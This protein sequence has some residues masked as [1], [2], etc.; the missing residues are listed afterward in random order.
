MAAYAYHFGGARRQA[1]LELLAAAAQDAA[2]P[3]DITDWFLRLP[4][5]A[6]VR[7]L[8]LARADETALAQLLPAR[9]RRLETALG[10]PAGNRRLPFAARLAEVRAWLRLTDEIAWLLAPPAG[11]PRPTPE[12]ARLLRA[13]AREMGIENSAMRE[14]RYLFRRGGL[15]GRGPGLMRGGGR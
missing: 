2:A 10:R 14:G 15:V 11:R 7:P 6:S 1:V 9:L 13:F 5:P 8:W 4:T 3:A 12:A